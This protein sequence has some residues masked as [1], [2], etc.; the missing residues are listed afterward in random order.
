MVKKTI[1]AFESLNSNV[2]AR[3]QAQITILGQD[4]HETDAKNRTST[5]SASE[6]TN[7]SDMVKKT[8]QAL[9]SLYSDVLDRSQAEITMLGQYEHETDTKNQI[10][11]YSAS[12]LTN[13]SDMVKKTCQAL[14][15]LNSDV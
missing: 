15:S 7:P 14:E 6:L 12:E 9:E 1:Q 2:Q 8:C 5:N 3:S 11:T 13:P 4:E 10:S